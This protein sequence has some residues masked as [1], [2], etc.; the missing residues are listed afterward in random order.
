MPKY[1]ITANHFDKTRLGLFVTLVDVSLSGYLD[2][3]LTILSI[4]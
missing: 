3:Q 4:N 2:Y 1:P